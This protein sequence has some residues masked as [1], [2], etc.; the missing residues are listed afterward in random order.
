MKIYIRLFCLL[1]L[2]IHSATTGGS[3]LISEFIGGASIPIPSEMTK[4]SDQQLELMLPGFKG[5]QVAYQ[6]G[7]APK[8]IIAFYQKHMPD[9]GWTPYAALVSEQGLLVFTK[10]NQSVLIMVS[11]S[12][13]ATTL[14]ILVGTMSPN[15]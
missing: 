3:E 2:L 4:A 14:A 1:L 9:N 8:E 10:A 6:G 12:N 7:V 13:G 15:K 5:G 11:E